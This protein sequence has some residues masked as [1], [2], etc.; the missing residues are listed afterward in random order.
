MKKFLLLSI[1]YFCSILYAHAASV[2][3]AAPNTI[4][5][6]HAFSV[7]V[8][9]S[10]GGVPVNAFDITLTYPSDVTVF[11][12]YTDEGSIKK[13]WITSPTDSSGEIHFAGLISG[14]VDGVYTPDNTKAQAIPLVTLLFTSKS[15]G[16]GDFRVVRSDILKNN[17]MGSSLTH[18]ISNSTIA[19]LKD[20]EG[21]DKS[22]KDTVDT[23]LPEPFDISFIKENNSSGT[24]AL[25]IF[26][27]IDKISGIE[28]YQLQLDDDTWQD[29]KSP[30]SV[31]QNIFTKRVTIRALDYNG[32][33][34]EAHGEIPGRVSIVWLYVVVLLGIIWYYLFVVRKNN[35]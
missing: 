12:G 20:S 29:V 10:T 4:V 14:G 3:I 1:F 26:S 22:A 34:R 8:Q 23:E 17:G 28:K 25:L 27:T 31:T 11:K 18:T 21:S 7:G 32:N 13:T 16:E 30:L 9:L 33:I 15:F 35:K 24:P 5:T 2:T 19:V 6:N